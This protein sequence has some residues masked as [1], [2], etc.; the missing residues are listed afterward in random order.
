MN[1]YHIA[2]ISI[3]SNLGQKDEN[4]R[5][6]IAAL[7]RSGHTRLVDQSPLYQT[8]PVDYL[9]QE[10]FV[11]CVVKNETDLDP[12]NLLSILKSIERAAGRVKDSIRFGPRI[13]DMDIILFDDLVMRAPTLTVPHPRMHKR[14]F[15]LKPMCDIDPDIH[16]PVL[17]RTMES[18]LRDLDEQGQRIVE[19]K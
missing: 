18:L 14:R 2:Y 4:C 7:I 3:G 5:S 16:H 1:P 8:E 13:L 12:L 19:Y 9:D 15:V 10:W 17:K 11:N 6:G